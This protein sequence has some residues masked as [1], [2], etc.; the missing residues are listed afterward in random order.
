MWL[1]D[2]DTP[3]A[4]DKTIVVDKLG[5]R[6][7]V[8][9]VKGT[10][11][12]HPDGSTSLAHEQLPPLLTPEYRGK[13]GESSL[14][15]EADMISDKPG[16]DILLNAE[17]H[18]PEGKP[19]RELTV[20]F[21]LG[22]LKKGLTVKGERVFERSRLGDVVASQ[23]E[24]FVSMPIIYERAYGGFDRTS[25]D[26]KQQ[27]MFAPNPVGT[28]VCA[29]AKDLLGKTA[30][31]IEL[32]GGDPQP[33]RAIGFGPLCSYWEPRRQY[34]GTYDAHWAAH[35]KPLLPVDYDERWNMCAPPDQQVGKLERSDLT[36]QLHNL[37]PTQS[38]SFRLPRTHLA[39]RTFFGSY[40]KLEPSE[41][42]AR[43]HT[44]IVEPS[45]ARV[46]MVWQTRLTCGSAVDDIDS[47]RVTEKMYV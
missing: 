28:G 14:H 20:G 16:T 4:A 22:T 9:V 24:P 26:P 2:N 19:V 45:Q 3:Y 11:A 43:L 13:P 31:N 37:M 17:A 33:D 35:Q 42:R 47:T 46:V 30:A 7:W 32:P 29:N 1:I 21:S 25:Q 10:F 12:I 38:F 5:A 44:V 15:Y 18:A 39:F 23:A 40:T 8:V 6:H 36:V 27:V 34:A 41:H